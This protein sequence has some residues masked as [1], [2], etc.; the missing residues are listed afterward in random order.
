MKSSLTQIERRFDLSSSH[1]GL[2]DGG[3]EMGANPCFKFCSNILSHTCHILVKMCVFLSD[4]LGGGQ[5]TCC[6]SPWLVILGPSYTDP[7]LL[8]WAASSWLWGPLALVW[9]TSS[10]DGKCEEK[11]I[12]IIFKLLKWLKFHSDTPGFCSYKYDTVVQ[13]SQNNSV[14]IAA[15]EDPKTQT[16][17]F[18]ED[19]KGK[20][21]HGTWTV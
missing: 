17:S 11:H 20:T 8:L 16:E 15:C 1:T 6:S 7:G 9:Y 10:W 13:D 3:F 4:I 12:Y 21:A 18:V 14:S 5:A 19:N 2:I